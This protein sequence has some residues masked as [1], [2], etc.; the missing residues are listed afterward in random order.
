MSISTSIAIG[1]GTETRSSV[2][3]AACCQDF[4]VILTKNQAMLQPFTFTDLFIDHWKD[5][6]GNFK[7]VDYLVY[8]SW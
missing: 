7:K 1:D 3:D 6:R 2:V 8:V 4:S 5:G